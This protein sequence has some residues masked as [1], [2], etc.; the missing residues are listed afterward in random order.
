MVMHFVRGTFEC[1][2]SPRRFQHAPLHAL[3]GIIESHP[4][5]TGRIRKPGS[6]QRVSKA[7]RGSFGF[8]QERRSALQSFAKRGCAP[9]SS[10]KSSQPARVFTDSSTN[11]EMS[12]FGWLGREP[13]EG[14]DR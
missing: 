3:R 6:I 4:Q 13:A 1:G 8:A 11:D 5:R 10:R 9:H 14:L 7:L 2:A 12:K